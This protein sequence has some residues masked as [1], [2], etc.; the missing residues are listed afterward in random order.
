L[1]CS[2]P[3]GRDPHTGRRRAHLRGLR[4]RLDTQTAQFNVDHIG[5]HVRTQVPAQLGRVFAHLL[6]RRICEQ[7]SE[8]R[9]CARLVVLHRDRL[10]AKSLSEYA[11]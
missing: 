9:L 11:L 4:G 2:Q 5:G 10:H 6:M 7:L 3:T 1:P 8:T